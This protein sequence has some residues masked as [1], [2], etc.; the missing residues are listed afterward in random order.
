MSD[1]R[2]PFLLEI[3]ATIFLF[4]FLSIFKDILALRSYPVLV[5]CLLHRSTEILN[6]VSRGEHPLLAGGRMTRKVKDRLIVGDKIIERPC[7]SHA[8][9]HRISSTSKKHFVI[10]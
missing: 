4:E 6:C 8:N 2:V 3:F 7:K 9:F 5:L 10:P 1:Y